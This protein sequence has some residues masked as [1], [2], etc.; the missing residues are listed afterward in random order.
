MPEDRASGLLSLAPSFPHRHSAPTILRSRL[1]YLRQMS[2]SAS[3]ASA[4]LSGTKGA[5][6]LNLLHEPS[7][8]RVD[9]IFVRRSLPNICNCDANDDVSC[10]CMAFKVGPERPGAFHRRILGL[11]GPRSGCHTSPVLD[12]SES[13]ASDMIQIGRRCNRVP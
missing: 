11:S 5:L 6:G 9:F 8:P 3:N 2:S 10:R 4:S 7:E 12:M 1:R 13:I